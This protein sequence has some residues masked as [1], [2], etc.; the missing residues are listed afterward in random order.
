MVGT[1]INI[2]AVSVGSTL[3]VMLGNRFP[4]RIQETVFDGLGLLTLFIG[5]QMAFKTEN[6]LI[7]LGSLLVGGVVG[8]LFKIEDR[9]NRLGEILQRTFSMERHKKFVEGFVTASLLF[10]VGPMAILGSIR[11]GLTGDYTILA[12]KSMLDGFASLGFAS[13]LGWGVLFSILTVFLFQGSITL[14]AAWI[15]KL[16]TTSMVNEMTAAGGLIIVGIG[17]RLLKIKDIRVGNFLP[18][19]AIA[20]TTV[21]ILDRLRPWIDLLKELINS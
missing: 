1:L 5:F 7:V 21:F 14:S 18:A 11:D 12:V 16:L 8:E 2:A 20:P 4:Q 10:C 9:L 17:I 19:L 3:G 13:A 6:V 15:Q